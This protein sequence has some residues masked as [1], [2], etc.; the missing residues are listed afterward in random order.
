MILAF[1]SSMDAIFY[2]EFVIFSFSL[3]FSFM[4]PVSTAFKVLLVYFSAYDLAFVYLNSI[5]TY[6]NGFCW[7]IFAL[8]PLLLLLF[9]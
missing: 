2:K 5:E 4:G 9:L 8:S 1:P 6:M 7:G 3:Y